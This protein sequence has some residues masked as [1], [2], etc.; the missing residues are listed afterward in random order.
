M[1]ALLSEKTGRPIRYVSPGLMRFF[2]AKRKLGIPKMMIFV[3]IMLHYLPRY[4]K[5]G[6]ELTGTVLEITGRQPLTLADF[7][8]REKSKFNP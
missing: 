6:H 2:R 1:A 5:R 4:S 7:I 8:E 3:M